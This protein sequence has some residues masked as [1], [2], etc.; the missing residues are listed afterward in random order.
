MKNK[1]L[2]DYLLERIDIDPQ[3]LT[4]LFEQEKIDIFNVA[5]KLIEKHG[6]DENELGKAW[7][8]Y[9]GFAY[10]DPC[11]SIVN[12][13]YIN[14]A[15]VE[16]ILENKALP[17]YK[18]GRAVTVSTSNP[19]NPYLQDKLEKKL[20]EIVSLVFCFP[21]DIEIYLQMNRLLG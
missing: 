2:E 19:K 3:I 20:D 5:L 9:L 13:E 14:K 4:D 21:F 7:G 12:K 15:G 18:F 10:V 1:D 6:I 8:S 17:L 16:F 11:S